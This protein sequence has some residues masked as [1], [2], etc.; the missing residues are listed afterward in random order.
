MSASPAGAG[1]I[2]PNAGTTLTL[3][4]VSG[5]GTLT[6]GGQ[7]VTLL[8]GTLDTTAIS[9][10]GQVKLT[11]GFADGGAP[12][13]LTV[14]NGGTLTSLG[15]AGFSGDVTLKQGTLVALGN[16]AFG[17]GSLA[18]IPTGAVQIDTAGSTVTLGNALSLSGGTLGMGPGSLTF[19]QPV[20]ISS[21]TTIQ[22]SGTLTLSGGVSGSF[23]L[24]MTG[25]GKLALGGTL[26]GVKVIVPTADQFVKLA[27]LT[28][29]NGA[30]VNDANGTVLFS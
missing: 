30:I 3:G 5:L 10:E 26:S 6:L 8:T 29:T 19:S 1:T 21:N 15:A 7:G 14:T 25:A 20:N 17:T 23:A 9:V 28:A 12:G 27:G 16:N 18:V 24:K 22:N 2:N 4:V 13:S 11:S